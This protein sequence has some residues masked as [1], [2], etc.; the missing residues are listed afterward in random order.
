[1]IKKRL[2]L[3][4]DLWGKEKSAWVE[5][6]V[7]LL[8]SEFQI[9]YYDCCEL[10]GIDKSKYTQESL[11]QQFVSGGIERAVE[12]L[13]KKEKGIIDILSFSIGGTIAWKAA[14]R[15]LKI[16]KLYGVSATRLRYETERPDCFIKLFYGQED[17]YKPGDEWFEKM[18]IEKN[19]IA[20]AGH[21]LYMEKEYSKKISFKIVEAG[22]D[23]AVYS[24]KK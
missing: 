4:S 24:Q 17:R 6:Y 21:Q 13:L 20:K 3:L 18:T 12:E 8:Q 14:L 9:Q 1:M 15:G 7:E 10:G 2:I 11:H 5:P 19:V 22:L 16:E 23:N